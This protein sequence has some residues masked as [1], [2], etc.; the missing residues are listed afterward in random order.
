[1]VCAPGFSWIFLSA[2]LHT[3]APWGAQRP[4]RPRQ[5]EPPKSQS[6]MNS[7]LWRVNR[8]PPHPP[9]YLFGTIHVP[10]TRVWDF[11]P[12]RSKQAFHSS[13]NVF[14]ELDLTDPLTISKLTSCQLLPHG[15]NLQTLL[16]RDLYRRLKRHLDYVKHMMPYWMTAD[17]RGRGLYADYL[18]NAIAGN[19]E[20]K[21]PV[22]VMLMVNSLTEWDVRSRG[23]PVLD[24]YLAQEAERM[25]KTTGAV[26]RVE[27]QC[28][29]LNGLNFSQ[30]LFALNQ[31]LLQHEGV[32]A[33]SLQGSYTTE[34]L[35]THYN[36][37]DLN[38]IIFNHDTSQLPQFIN[39]SLPAH[40]RMTAQQIDSYFRQELIYKRNERMAR[41]VS[42]L[43]QRNPNHTYFFAFGA[44]H[45]LGNH[46]VLDILRQEGYEIVHMPPDHQE[47]ESF[48]TSPTPSPPPFLP[49]SLGCQRPPEDMPGLG[50]EELPHMLL[51][52]SLSQLEEF[53]RQKRP[54]KAHRGH[55]RTRLFSDLW[56]RIGDST[57]PPPS[58]RIINGYVTVAPPLTH[59]EQHRRTEGYATPKQ[60]A[61][62]SSSPPDASSAQP[63]LV[64]STLTLSCILAWMSSHILFSS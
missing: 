41:R 39:S 31:T 40:D 49:P 17:Q 58:V 37:G 18:F 24:L 30:V 50:D 15:E 59:Q 26:E 22:W 6:D 54:R 1:M 4:D 34:D 52:D 63:A 19:W 60:P 12:D 44:G 43:L 9:S 7:F 13:H 21:R 64:H 55:G 53:G 27:E 57:T 8:A 33:G 5:C 62:A 10:Y 61:P 47:A 48:D 3:V 20:R 16:P 25:G 42:A 14:F 32:R 36:C 38:S 2:L 28:H 51:P 45:F 35:I 56:V 23:T 11:I 29:P 46:S